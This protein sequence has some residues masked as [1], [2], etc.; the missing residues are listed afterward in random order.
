MKTHANR[1]SHWRRRIVRLDA[2][3]PGN[4][5]TDLSDEVWRYQLI[6]NEAESHH[7]QPGGAP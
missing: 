7:S 3:T 4:A 6:F 5:T 2:D 1:T